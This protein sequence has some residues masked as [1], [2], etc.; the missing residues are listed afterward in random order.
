LSVAGQPSA[1]HW[2]TVLRNLSKDPSLRFS[3]SGRDLL[4]W[5]YIHAKGPD[6][7]TD[8]IDAMPPHSAYVVVEVARGC[9]EEWSAFA[10]Q[11]EQRL[12]HEAWHRSARSA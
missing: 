10:A 8:M 5:L 1:R 6:G 9:A 12:P 11:L 3:E 4:R 7:G 2:T